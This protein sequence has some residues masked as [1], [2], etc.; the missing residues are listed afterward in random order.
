M[1][2]A[3][4]ALSLL[5]ALSARPAPALET[6]AAH[7]RV[8]SGRARLVEREAIVELPPSPRAR[9][10]APGAYLELGA[11]SALELTWRGS[12]SVALRGPA[13]LEVHPAELRIARFTHLELEVRRGDLLLEL[14]G[15]RRLEA[16]PAALELTALPDGTLELVHRGGEPARLLSIE[17]SRVRTRIIRAGERV[18]SVGSLEG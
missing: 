2:L 1:Q 17:G 15:L 16:G 3:P 9:A 14:P 5:F 11:R 7:A 8:T 12:A 4:V 18:R 13:S 10:L 6:L